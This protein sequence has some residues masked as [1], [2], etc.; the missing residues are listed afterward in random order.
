MIAGL[1]RPHAPAL[2][3]SL[4]LMLLQSV[5]TLAQPW[6]GGQLT[7]RLVLGEGF[8]TLLWT[9]FVLIAAQALL[10]YVTSLQLQRV[11]GHLVAA[12]GSGLYRHLQSLPMAWHH[13][14]E[15]GDV[16]ALLSGDVYR[17]GHYLTGTLVPLLPL[18]FTFTGA[19]VM[20][21]RTAPAIALAIGVLMPVLFVL[22]RLAGRRLRP[23][24]AQSM[25]AWADQASLAERNLSMLALIKAFA[26][27]E[28]E[29][30]R[31]AARVQTT[32]AIDLR[33]ATLDG[34]ISPTVHVLGAGAILL[35]LG[36]AGH[37]VIR[38][39]LGV[40]ELVS[41][42]LYGMVLVNPVSQLARVY[43]STQ[44]ARGTMQR[45]R[46]ALS[47]APED[48]RGTR[49]FS[50]IRGEIRF[51][52]LHFAYPDR[53]TLFAGFDLHIAAGETVALTGA[54]G[55]G[56]STLA[57]LLLRLLEPQ[58]GRICIDGIDLCD[59]RLADLRRGIGLVSQ[60]VLLFSASV[61]DNLR[62]GSP[63]A[64]TEE[65]E[66]VARIARAHD[67]IQRLPQGYDTVIG[68]DGVRL[69]GGQ[70][71][72]IALARALLKDPAILILDEAT[73]MFDPDGE[74]DFIAECHELLRDR[75]V[76]L[77]T[78]RPASLALADR[79]LKLD[80]GALRAV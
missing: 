43:G 52:N 62:Y 49:A 80:Q 41:L 18:L 15:R 57:H 29:A 19:L 27:D 73:A 3:L 58:Q 77:I 23:L 12:A 28:D 56:K 61:A 74:R 66:R 16:L 6:L 51:E 22:M 68:D 32:R 14:R 63:S 24:A 39:E 5:A 26:A 30:T 34:A 8:G 42:F 76:L 47:A 35:L 67:F 60:Q 2:G 44:A 78:H 4:L 64:T 13:G 7:D 25:Q 48:D 11:S 17:L 71:Q 55:A 45:L 59:F 70:R 21:L 10:G 38:N 37:L 31:Y 9:L 72:R 33:Y 36:T 50:G 79:V 75:T 20:M 46:A 40:G 1:L 53:E 54:N 65:I 69:S